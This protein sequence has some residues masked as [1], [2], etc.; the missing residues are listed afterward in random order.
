MSTKEVI[1]E[2]VNVK[3]KGEC[4]GYDGVMKKAHRTSTTVAIEDTNL[5]TLS[6]QF[7]DKC[8]GKSILKS[9][10]ERK[11][12]LMERVEIFRERKQYFDSRFKYIK[13]HV[14]NYYNCN[15]ILF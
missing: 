5:F 6:E 4:F 3:G 10:I 13:T 2:C 9:E 8:F 11:E 15:I 12:F 14:N 7:F 1:N